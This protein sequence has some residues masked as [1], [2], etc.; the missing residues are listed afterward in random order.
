MTFPYMGHAEQGTMRHFELHH[1]RCA[2][3]PLDAHKDLRF[4]SQYRASLL[5]RTAARLNRTLRP[6][7]F[8]EEPSIACDP[9]FPGLADDT[10]LVGR[11]QSHLY[12]EDIAPRLQKDFQLSGQTFA[13]CHALCEQARAYPSVGLHIRRTDYVNSEA[14]R[15]VIQAL[16]V[17]YYSRAL[18]NGHAMLGTNVQLHIVSDDIAWCREQALF[19]DAHTF[20]GLSEADHPHVEEF[21]VL[22]YCRHFVSSNSTFAW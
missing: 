12:F 5:K 7:G 16:P 4:G 8:Y 18:A 15:N 3:R 22:R 1:F 21:E 14:Y 6:H 20:V 11:F 10:V 13:R 9:S 2:G 17:D 19:C